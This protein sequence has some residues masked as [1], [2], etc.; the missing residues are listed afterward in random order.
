[1]YFIT[2]L[3]RTEHGSFFNSDVAVIDIYPSIQRL[4][5]DDI[6]GSM[7]QRIYGVLKIVVLNYGVDVNA[8]KWYKLSE[9]GVGGPSRF[10]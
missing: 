1:M 6:Y 2:E 5:A 8:D 7:R 10:K 4:P 3:L 9:G